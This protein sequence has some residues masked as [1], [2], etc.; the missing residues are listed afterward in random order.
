MFSCLVMTVAI[1]LT[2]MYYILTDTNHLVLT[3]TWV[4]RLVFLLIFS[5][6]L[7]N[8][9]LGCWISKQ[10]IKQWIKVN[11][12]LIKFTN[13]KQR[14]NI[15]TVPSTAFE[16]RYSHSGLNRT[17]KIIFKGNKY[18]VWYMICYIVRETAIAQ[19]T[20]PPRTKKIRIC[21]LFSSAP[22]SLFDM[23]TFTGNERKANKTSNHASGWFA[24]VSLQN[25][26]SSR[27]QWR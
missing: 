8:W 21:A 23:K 7:Y 4:H 27:S 22:F 17:D 15:Q 25:Y 5:C 14:I 1:A 10:E 20:H 12:E 2:E 3:L 11:R 9:R 13:V 6:L 18:T 16:I 19:A 24:K 26:R